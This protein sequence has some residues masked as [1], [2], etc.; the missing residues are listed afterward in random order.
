MANGQEQVD[1]FETIAKGTVTLKELREALSQAKKALDE[2]EVGTEKYQ[3]RL[4]DVIA[5]QNLMKGAV[6]GTTAS[7][8]DMAKAATGDVKSYNALV[9]QMANLKRELRNVDVSTE[10]GAAKFKQLAKEVDATNKQLKKMDEMQ[11]SFVRNVGNYKSALEG[12]IPPLKGIND[13]L[14]L[15]GKQPILGIITLLAP[16]ISNIT[17]EVKGNKKM[18]DALK[19]VLDFLSGL[20]DTI[21]TTVTDIIEKV[22]QFVSGNGLFKKIIEGVMGVGNAILQFVIAPFKGIVA[23]IKV[24]QDEG[25]KGIRNAAKAFGNEM[26]SGVAFKSN[27]QAGQDFADSIIAGAKSRKKEVRQAG[28]DIG[29]ELGEGLKEGLDAILDKIEKDW[30]KKLDDRQ[31]LHEKRQKE[32][33]DYNKEQAKRFLEEQEA[34]AEEL[35]EEWYES[36]QKQAQDAEEAAQRKIAAVNAVAT[37]TSSILSTIADAY[38]NNTELTEREAKRVKNLRVIAATIDMI[39]GAVTAFSTAQELGPIAG[40]IVGAINA[41]AVIASGLVNIAKIKSTN[42]SKDSAGTSV[43]PSAP[44]AVQAP[45]LDNAVPQTTVVTGAKTETA[46]NR[47]SQP[48]KVYIL[49]SDIEAAG[50]TSKVQ[51]AESSF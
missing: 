31:K 29:K 16:L 4:K 46:L 44:A 28:N 41:A 30:D 43:T 24:L 19:P 10:E 3:S 32:I 26:K 36:Y 20:L 11:G 47:A 25:V 1:I 14:G 37:A 35:A 18:L 15:M 17:A 50:D 12:A 13:G 48:Q 23:A 40:P 39:Q 9:N 2:E 21:V 22:A 45:A 27:F 49:Q 5:L 51:V 33:A 34:E 38:E 42:V 8:E 7:L 6:N